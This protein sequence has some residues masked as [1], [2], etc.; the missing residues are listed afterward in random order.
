MLNLPIEPCPKC[1]GQG[2]RHI[3]EAGA[4]LREH[5]LEHG[6]TA[7]TMA[8]ELRVTRQLVNDWEQG[9]HRVPQDVPEGWS[10]VCQ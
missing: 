1:A 4:V 8:R 10:R 7:A 6:V 9:R 3:P 2:F 5:R